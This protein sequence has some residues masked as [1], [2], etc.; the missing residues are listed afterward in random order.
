MWIHSRVES[1]AITERSVLRIYSCYTVKT[2]KVAFA[3]SVL[4]GTE[5]QALAST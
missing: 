1:R 5:F 4:S 3:E 2:F